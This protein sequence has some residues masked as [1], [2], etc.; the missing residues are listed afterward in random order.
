MPSAN[1][2]LPVA[3]S[4]PRDYIADTNLRLEA[5][6]RLA[7]GE[8]NSREV[9]E[10]LRDRFGPPPA[11]VVTLAAACEL[12]QLAESLRVQSIVQKGRKLIFRLRNDARVDVDLLIQL[13]SETELA[14]FSPSGVPP[15]EVLQA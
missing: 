3:M 5:Y 12:K 10:E 1:I 6:R 11:D 14:T 4:V 2:D 13:V 7:S 15:P 8:E 9:L